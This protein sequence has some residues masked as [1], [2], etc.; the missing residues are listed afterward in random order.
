V[1]VARV[2]GSDGNSVAEHTFALLLAVARRLR[3]SVELRGQGGG[4][5]EELRGFELRGKTIGLIGVGRIGARVAE[6]ARAFGMRVLACDPRRDPEHARQAGFRYAPLDKVLSE[7][8]ILSLHAPLTAATR[9]LLN[10]KTLAKCREGVVI[11]NTARGG[12]IDIAALAAALESGQVGG[13]GLDVLED[14]RVL[15]SDVKNV[16]ASEIAQRVHA[17]GGRKGA[18]GRV[19]RQRQIEKLFFS[20]A[21]L[22]RP[23]VVFTPHIA[24]NT[25]ESIEAMA[26]GA[27]RNIEDFLE[28]RE[29]ACSANE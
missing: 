16:L 21:L 24:F 25:T 3:T 23:E 12:L 11:I 5:H 19:E 8:E 14:E 9:H 6:L 17:T 1:R 4:S 26:G 18:E 7:A 28:G 15:H 27:A 29:V 2:G 20:N 10:A 13:A 22:A